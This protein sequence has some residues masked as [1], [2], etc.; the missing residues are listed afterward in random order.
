MDQRDPKPLLGPRCLTFLGSWS[1]ANFWI[2]QNFL[3]CCPRLRF[4][5]IPPISLQLVVWRRAAGLPC[6]YFAILRGFPSVGCLSI[7]L[8]YSFDILQAWIHKS[9]IQLRPLESP[10]SPLPALAKHSLGTLRSDLK[11]SQTKNLTSLGKCP[12][13]LPRW[14]GKL[15]L[16]QL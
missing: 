13:Q 15:G 10:F 3:S 5:G 4:L 6:D 16:G 12:F 2:R 14:P 8:C 7:L 9:R 1:G 11:R